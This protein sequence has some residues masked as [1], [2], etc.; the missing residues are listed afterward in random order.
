M[1]TG[2]GQVRD[3][4]AQAAHHVVERQQGALPE[5]DDHRLFTGVSTVLRRLRGPMGAS[6]VQERERH[7]ATVV[8][9]SP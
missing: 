4:V 3:A 1:Q 2:S 6:D 7:F 8:R 9:L 5:R